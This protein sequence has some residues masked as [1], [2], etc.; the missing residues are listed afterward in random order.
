MDDLVEEEIT[1][2]V[3]ID[4]K[5]VEIIYSIYIPHTANVILN[6]IKLVSNYG[7]NTIDT[8]I[9]DDI[10]GY[11]IEDSELNSYI[12]N[13]V[14][15]LANETL[16]TIGINLSP[17]ATL[18]T[19]NIILST[20]D[21]ILNA[22]KELVVFISDILE[23]DQLDNI[24]KICKLVENYNV[25][26]CVTLYNSIDYVSNNAIEKLLPRPSVDTVD[27]NINTISINDLL[28]L[29][30]VNVVNFRNSVTYKALASGKYDIVDNL[31]S[32]T[33]EL[34]LAVINYI[35][36]GDE[37]DLNNIT[38]GL[39]ALSYISRDKTIDIGLGMNKQYNILAK[40]VLAGVSVSLREKIVDIY[41]KTVINIIDIHKTVNRV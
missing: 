21:N 19:Y 30:R 16:M 2:N 35:S 34:T 31:D 27:E 6:I 41:N 36:S 17:D 23:D 20:L 29:S 9:M 11:D 39:T 37:S 38:Y 8:I 14:I 7:N 26:S 22:D 25:E 4:D 28:V 5:L 33:Q 10:V 15:R 32:Y 24:E 40:T 12:I 1:S 18:T 3:S 13:K